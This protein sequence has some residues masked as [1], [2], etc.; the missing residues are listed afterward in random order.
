M[1]PKFLRTEV[2]P[3]TSVE[4]VPARVDAAAV[5]NVT[6]DGAVYTLTDAADLDRFT[7]VLRTAAHH[8]AH[9]S[10][11]TA[12]MAQLDGLKVVA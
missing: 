11:W 9:S 10:A 7:D 3:Y 8:P 1:I 12:V 4:I 2:V 6:Y 5:M